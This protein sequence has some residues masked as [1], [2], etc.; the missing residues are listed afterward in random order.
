M[1]ENYE[2]LPQNI[3][4]LLY[5]KDISNTNQPVFL[6]GFSGC[7]KSTLG[8]MIA[9]K[10]EKKFIDIDNYIVTKHNQSISQIFADKGEQGFRLI[11][12]EALN[13]I[14]N[15]KNIIIATG[16][17]TPCFFDNM[18]L[19]NKN[20]ITIYLKLSPEKLFERLVTDKKSRPL[21]TEKDDKELLEY[22]NNELRK[23]EKYYEKAKINFSI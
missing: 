5:R 1:K 12:K 16:G 10:T 13:E 7:G 9:Q 23:R 6:I 4:R 20:G 8:A 11:E 18:E 2:R 19:M 17:G 15:L 22:I 3:K 21:L 14:L